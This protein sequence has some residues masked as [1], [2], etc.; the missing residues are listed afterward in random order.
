MNQDEFDWSKIRSTYLTK[1]FD[2]SVLWVCKEHPHL[3][4]THNGLSGVVESK[5]QAD[6]RVALTRYAMTV[7]L[8]LTM[9]HV[10]FSKACCQGTMS[11][12]ANSY[13]TFF[14]GPKTEED[15][16]TITTQSETETEEPDAA[17]EHVEVEHA[18]VKASELVEGTPAAHKLRQTVSYEQF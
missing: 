11:E 15:K 3:E 16:I 4:K 5:E 1:Y 13:D 12:R 18:P 8:R 10:Y 14:F 6:E 9:F 7:S 2:R 17:A